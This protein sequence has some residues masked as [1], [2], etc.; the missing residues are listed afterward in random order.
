MG[1]GSRVKYYVFSRVSQTSN[2]TKMLLWKKNEENAQNC[3]WALPGNSK[4]HA[5][6]F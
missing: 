4:T 5:F 6:L 2:T 1:Q 3:P